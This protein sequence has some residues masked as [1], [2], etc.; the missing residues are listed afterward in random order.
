MSVYWSMYHNHD[1]AEAIAGAARA[2]SKVERVKDDFSRLE[3]KIEH[4]TRFVKA[5]FFTG[6]IDQFDGNLWAGFLDL[7]QPVRGVLMENSA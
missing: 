6:V 1:S 4:F 3:N 5:D 2:E 7:L